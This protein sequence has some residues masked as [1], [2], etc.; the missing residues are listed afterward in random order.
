ME[1]KI[2]ILG[3]TFDPVH[4]EHISLAESAINELGLDIL[5][6]IPTYIP[7]HKQN[8]KITAFEHRIQMLRLAFNNPKIIISDYEGAMGGASYTY[9]TVEH[10]KQPN[11]TLYFIVGADMLV[12]FKSWRF[13]ERILQSCQLAVFLRKGFEFSLNDEITYF[14]NNYG[15]SFTLLNYVGENLS[16]TKIRVYSALGVP[17]DNLISPK[18]K[19]YISDNRLY[20]SQYKQLIDYVIK[21]EKPSRVVHTANVIICAL[22]RAKEL[23]LDEDKVF[24]ACLLHDVAKYQDE[25]AYPNC[26]IP[27]DVPAPVRHAFLGAYIAETV[28]GVTD[29]EII[30]AI[31]YH[32]SGKAN[33]GSLA[34]LV[35]TADMVEEGRTYPEAKHLQHYFAT[36]DFES[37]FKECLSQELQHLLKKLDEKS[38]YKETLNC[39]NY[40][41]NEKE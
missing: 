34:K 10:F 23:A 13:P 3:G 17:T 41:I 35:F 31:R 2:G 1:K 7:P 26:A 39:Y 20:Y 27:N 9:L 14:K 19:E 25:T 12:D 28:L 6:V 16:A 21:V 37:A 40:Y 33:M 18:V 5:Y 24:L 38:I 4:N 29:K 11:A 30:D 15:K 8:K 32:T 22:S 36:H